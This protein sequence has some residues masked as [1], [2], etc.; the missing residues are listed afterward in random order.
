MGFDLDADAGIVVV[1]NDA[2]VVFEHRQ[3]PRFRQIKG[4]ASNGLLEQ[5]VDH[6]GLHRAIGADGASILNQTFEGFVHAVFRPGL[7]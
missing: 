2:A 7:R 6:H 3:T 1:L 4:C 5:I